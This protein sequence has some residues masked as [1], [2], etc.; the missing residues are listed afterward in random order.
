MRA[1]YINE[2]FVEDSDAITDMGIGII[3]KLNNEIQGFLTYKLF[4]SNVL[5]IKRI[6]IVN[7]EKFIIRLLSTPLDTD[8]IKPKLD[9]MIKESLLTDY[10]IIPNKI[11]V[12]SFFSR[13][14]PKI[15]YK[16]KIKPEYKDLFKKLQKIYSR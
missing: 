12:N 14:A 15:T 16:A 11:N 7:G 5:F 8:N 13:F 6:F 9:K 1:K 3:D 10:L 4:S 2:K